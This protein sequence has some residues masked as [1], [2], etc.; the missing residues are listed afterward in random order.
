MFKFIKKIAVFVFITFLVLELLVR[1]FHLQDEKPN[2]YIDEFNVEKILPNQSGFSVTGN[3]R[4][5][6]GEFKINSF[7]FNSIYDSYKPSVDSLEIALIGDS[8]IQG[9]HENYKTSLGQKLEDKLSNYK[10][11]EFGYAGW[12]LAD[13]LHLLKAYDSIFKE[14]DEVVIYIRFTDDL[15]RGEYEVT[16]RL[17]NINTPF[18]KILR[19]SKLIIYAKDIG[20]VNGL[21][22]GIINIIN[23]VKKT[24]ELSKEN[25]ITEKTNNKKR[26]LNF[27]KLIKSYP[28]D[29]DKCVFL[30]DYS[31]CDKAFVDY[32]SDNDFKTI[33]FSETF[34]KSNKEPTLVYDQHWNS[35]GRDL[36]SSLISDYYKNK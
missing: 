8:F 21:T 18:K 23:K 4:Q 29:K 20:V 5:N 32:L 31:L 2:R 3:R 28:I 25:S 17:K 33:D 6:V 9:F 22:G 35:Y 13:E 10:V 24:K 12:D 11:Y 1:F 19:N 15:E 27:E 34:K 30:I 26:L 14:I 16:N 36:L 7:G